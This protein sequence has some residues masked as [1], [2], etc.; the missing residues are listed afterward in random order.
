MAKKKTRRSRLKRTKSQKENLLKKLR[1]LLS[2]DIL[3]SL[4]PLG[5][6]AKAIEAVL[7]HRV[8]IIF[9]PVAKHMFKNLP[10]ALTISQE[11]QVRLPGRKGKA[12]FL[13]CFIYYP[14]Q[15]AEETE[16]LFAVAHELGHIF[17]HYDIMASSGKARRYV[18]LVEAVRKKKREKT[19]RVFQVVFTAREEM[20][21][22]AFA[23][24]IAKEYLQPGG[25]ALAFALPKAFPKRKKA[26]TVSVA[27]IEYLRGIK[28]E[29]MFSNVNLAELSQLAS[30]AQG[31]IKKYGERSVEKVFETQLAL[32]AQSLGFYWFQPVQ[33]IVR[34][35][36]FAF[37]IILPSR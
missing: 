30:R 6:I 7:L 15:P 11:I 28:A 26:L 21:A 4:S 18:E 23:H 35:I 2:V 32:L 3:P 20:E 16:A 13:E 36:C 31:I 1:Q 9:R 10:S 37:L 12:K 8:H 27:P 33:D 19:E 24:V 17:L 29:A 22:D 25:P 14:D 34:W 5:G